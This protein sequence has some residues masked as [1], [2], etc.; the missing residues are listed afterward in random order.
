MRQWV[1]AGVVS[2]LLA[3]GGDARPS[4]VHGS[5]AGVDAGPSEGAGPSPPESPRFVCPDGF[6]EIA[7]TFGTACEPP[8]STVELGACPAGEFADD[9][10]DDANVLFVRSGA[11]GGGGTRDRPL[12]TIREAMLRAGAGTVIALAK[13]TY[14]EGLDVYAG[15]AVRGAC[16]AETRIA[17]A[18][19]ADGAVKLLERGSSLSDVTVAPVSGAGIR[20][21][22]DPTLERVVI[23]GADAYAIVA[24]RGATVLLRDIVVRNTATSDDSFGRG[25]DVESGSSVI[26]ERALFEGNG[27][28]AV[29]AS[30]ADTTVTLADAILRDNGGD[31]DGARQLGAQDGARIDIRRA[32]FEDNWGVGFTAL[33]AGATVVL[34]DVVMRGFRTDPTRASSGIGVLAEAGRVEARRTRFEGADGFG[35]AALDGSTVALT[36]VV[37]RDVQRGDGRNGVALG[38]GSGASLDAMRVW[39][40]GAGAA[41]LMSQGVG[42]TVRLADVTVART[43]EAPASDIFGLAFGDGTHATLERVSISR[44]S[45]AAILVAGTTTILEAVDLA[46]V[47]TGARPDGTF[48]RA[49]EVQMGASATLRRA[50]LAGNRE[51]TALAVQ[52]STL[53]LEDVRIDDTLSRACAD[54]TCADAPAGTGL[55]AYADGQIVARRF[56]VDSAALCGVQIATGGTMRLEDGEI[57]SSTIGACVQVDGFD[58]ADITS[59]VVYADNGVNVDMAMHAVPTPTEPL[60]AL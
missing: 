15:I 36:D 33:G 59:S 17:P 57:R 31:L 9:L 56:V 20:L 7:D 35:I 21:M 23:E 55:G 44:T 26:V 13:G 51:V 54:T 27:G 24:Q 58:L 42:A 25:L 1:A 14:T 12:G 3:C 50:R 45:S 34:E 29:H 16:A 48:G 11:T 49:I 8:S 2:A 43:G 37:V 5:D 39:V 47:D 4:P 52:G 22:A 18:A 10:P 38:V 28:G 6:T 40:E 41:A 19:T 32:L 53:T 30:D 46:V 60:P